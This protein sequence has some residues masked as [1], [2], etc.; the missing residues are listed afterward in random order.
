M[1]KIKDVNK[2]YNDNYVLKNININLPNRG[3]IG[4]CGPSGCGKTTLLNAIASLITFEGEI[5]F[6]DI[7]YSKLSQNDKDTLR[8]SK[9]GFIFQDFKLFEFEN[10]RNNILLTLDVKTSNSKEDK[11]RKVRELLSIVG[12]Q[13][14]EN[15]MVSN[16][17]G[18]EKQRVAIARAIANSPKLILA[19]EPTGNLDNQNSE[20]IMNLLEAISKNA[21]VV[22]VSHD[23][24]LTNKYADQVIYLKDGQICNKKSI[25]ID[26]NKKLTLPIS[27]SK[28]ACKT[29]LSSLFCFKHALKN[30]QL[31]K[32]RTLFILFTTSLGLFGVGLGSIISDIISNNLYRS[33]SA[34]MDGNKVIVKN[35]EE[36]GIRKYKALDSYD[37]NKLYQRYKDDISGQGVYYWNDFNAF[38]SNYDFYIDTGGTKKYLPSFIPRLFN[39]YGELNELDDVYPYQ[40]NDLGDN[41]VVMGIDIST[42]N[43][44]CYQLHIPR[45]VKGLSDY[46]SFNSITINVSFDN[47]SWDYHTEFAINLIGFVLTKKPLFYHSSKGWNEYIFEN[48]CHLPSTNIITSNSKNPW[49]LK[50]SYYL[51]FKNN[52]D[53]FL[54]AIRFDQKYQDVVAEIITEKYYPN[55]YENRDPSSF[56]RIMLLKE[57]NKD[58]LP[59]HIPSYF[60]KASNKIND[61]IYGSKYSFAIYPE[62]LMMGFA[63][64]TYLSNSK[65]KIEEIIDLSTYLKYE[66]SMN[67]AIEEDVLEGHFAKNN[68]FVFNSKY[69]LIKGNEPSNYEEILISSKIKDVLSI[70]IGD[71]IYL[72]YPIKEALLANGYLLRDY[73]KA[74]LKVVG[75]TDSLKSEISHN[76][77]WTIMFFQTA[78]AMSSFDLIIDSVA[79]DIKENSENEVI[80]LLEKGFPT[81]KCYSPMKGVKESVQNVCKYIEIILLTIST[82]SVIISSLLLILSNNIHFKE[83]KK[84]IGLL[85]CMGVSRTQSSKLVYAY[86]ILMA[87]LSIIL[88]IFELFVVCFILG[89]TFSE[90][91][92]I[93]SVFVFNPVSL[94]YMLILDLSV[95]LLSCLII[96]RRLYNIN[97]L[98]YFD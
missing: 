50:K 38:F 26:E 32:W 28:I 42:L 14:K 68:G 13:N 20:S 46:L 8:L 31:K 30:I 96:K 66:E 73:R 58:D 17:S 15:E 97:P 51:E 9:M 2:K 62:S 11:E 48:Q 33:Y 93:E 63:R 22:M 24:E 67:I 79:L 39:E 21:L 61:V 44:I 19:D 64:E 27:R 12:L 34:L 85:R 78:L 60:L 90:I 89:K 29:S 16:L 1:I 6:N 35:K 7:K 87:F 70:D 65:D 57:N 3:F 75:I 72:A 49:D 52:K 40:V 23:E 5:I 71:E 76:N 47:N 54:E 55:Y 10:V 43:E 59:S 36:V 41:E 95:V 82:C 53:T 88:A 92:S 69:K 84:D 86:S 81:I 37:V 74:V 56:N 25:N 4:I 94:V 91:L 98:D 83:I 45:S 77:K 18:G 80:E